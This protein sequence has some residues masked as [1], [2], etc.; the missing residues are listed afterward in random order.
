MG[1]FA[2]SRQAVFTQGTRRGWGRG[3][4]LPRVP[5]KRRKGPTSQ[6]IF[7]DICSV[8]LGPC[9][10]AAWRVSVHFMPFMETA[11]WIKV[12]KSRN[13]IAIKINLKSQIRLI[14]SNVAGFSKRSHNLRGWR[15]VVNCWAR[16]CAIRNLLDWKEKRETQNSD[17]F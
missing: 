12:I 11:A 5:E 13:W 14:A 17:C 7:R 16:S 6:A 8:I 3:V 9:K 2:P 15:S 1:E 4:L 10:L